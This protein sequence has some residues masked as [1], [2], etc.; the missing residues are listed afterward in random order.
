M[1][2]WDFRYPRILWG[3]SRAF[4]RDV[5]YS[6][7]FILNVGVQKNKGIRVKH[8]TSWED[9]FF[10]YFPIWFFFFLDWRKEQFKEGEQLYYFIHIISYTNEKLLHL[11]KLPVKPGWLFI[12]WLSVQSQSHAELW[13]DFLL[14]WYHS[15]IQH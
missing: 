13:T 12:S 15:F 8:P 4:F 6:R 5:V 1:L 2:S 7:N 10:M 3:I 14:F 11:Y 9:V